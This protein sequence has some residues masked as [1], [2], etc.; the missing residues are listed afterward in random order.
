M[1]L[2][3]VWRCWK[4]DCVG[5]MIVLEL[6]LCWKILQ[7]WNQVLYSHAP[8]LLESLSAKL[9]HSHHWGKVPTLSFCS[10]LVVRL[11]MFSSGHDEN[12]EN[13]FWANT[14]IGNV[15]EPCILNISYHTC[16]CPYHIPGIPVRGGAEDAL[17]LSYSIGSFFMSRNCARHPGP[18]R[19]C[20][21]QFCCP[22]TWPAHDNGTSQRQAMLSASKI[23]DHTSPFTLHSLC[24]S[25]FGTSRFTLRISCRLISP[26]LFSPHL[27][28]SPFVWALFISSLFFSAVI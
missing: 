26:E 22:R 3:D 18:I 5:I 6:W 20:F 9:G 4:Y 21:V 14:H 7:S 1:C 25:V 12:P 10:S 16:T 17:R 27:A 28:S 8:L 23:T 11:L 13:P 19:A 15:L 2:E 24:A